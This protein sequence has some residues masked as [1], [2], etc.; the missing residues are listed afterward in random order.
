MLAIAPAKKERFTRY[1]PFYTLTAAAEKF[2]GGD[3]KEEGW[4]EAT[5]DHK[6]KKTMF[7]VRI[8][9]RSMEPILEE[10]SLGVFDSSVPD[11]ADGLILMV[12]SGKIDDPDGITI[13]RC[14]FSGRTETG[15]TFRYR[16]LRME[17]ENPEYKTIV[18]KNVASG[19]FKIVG[20]YVS[21]I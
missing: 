1:L 4:I 12:R 17:P 3:A 8:M 19:D 18:L 14:H 15:K 21:G 16:E 6:P 10:D 9:D 2:G 20:R 7:V 11:T 5:P 13:R